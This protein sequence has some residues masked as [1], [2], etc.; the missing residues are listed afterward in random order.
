METNSKSNISNMQQKGLSRLRNDGIIAT[1]PADKGGAGVTLSK[2]HYQIMIIQHLV[3]ENTYRKLDSSIDN[4]I[5]SKLLRFQRQY[6]IYFT[7]PE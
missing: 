1:K 7:E 5:Q 4:K 6:N 3:D 2:G